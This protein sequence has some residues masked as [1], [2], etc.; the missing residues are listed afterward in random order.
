MAAG[1]RIAIFP[2][3]FDPPTH[4]HLDLIARAARLFD[5]VIVAL[6]RNSAKQPLFTID[7]R[8]AMLQDALRH[9]PQVRVEAFDG[10]L[11]D[12]AT[13]H[14]AVAIV[15]GVRSATDL[16]Y[17]RQM[18]AMNRHLAPTVDTVFLTPSAQFAHISS[19]LVR[20]IASVGGSIDGLVPDS[21][22]AHLAA[23]SLTPGKS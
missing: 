6:L 7:E 15:R 13:R 5:V 16:D 21:V 14:G 12:F 11:V 9:L 17:E 20:E 4:G 10:L 18:A 22:V 1:P 19:T 23:R 8:A 3:S 2:G